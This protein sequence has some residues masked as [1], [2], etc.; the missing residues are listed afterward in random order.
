MPRGH[1]GSSES[2][3]PEWRQKRGWEPPARCKEEKD[4]GDE[5]SLPWYFKRGTD[6]AKEA[7]VRV[8]AA[9]E[10]VPE[11]AV[12]WYFKRGTREGDERG[13]K[14]SRS[15]DTFRRSPPPEPQVPWFFKRGT[16][17]QEEED[18]RLA[19]QTEAFLQNWRAAPPPDVKEEKE[20]HLSGE[21]TPPLGVA[22][23]P[24]CEGSD[25]EVTPPLP[26][27]ESVTPPLEEVQPIRPPEP[28]LPPKRRRSHLPPPPKPPPHVEVEGMVM[29]ALREKDPTIP[30]GWPAIV[31][32]AYTNEPDSV[33][34]LI[35]AKVDVNAVSSS[36]AS[37][38]WHAVSNHNLRM[39]YSLLEARADPNH[40]KKSAKGARR[41]LLDV[42][43]NDGAP[44]P[45]VNMLQAAGGLHREQLEGRR[46]P[47]FNPDQLALAAAEADVHRP[48]RLKIEKVVQEDTSF[49]SML[50]K[51]GDHPGTDAKS[52]A[53]SPSTPPLDDRRPGS[54]YAER[55]AFK[56]AYARKMLPL[57]GEKPV[58]DFSAYKS[59]PNS[60][61]YNTSVRP[62]DLMSSLMSEAPKRTYAGLVLP[63]IRGLRHHEADRWRAGL[64]AAQAP[65]GGSEAPEVL[66]DPW[67][68]ALAGKEKAKE[69]P[70][71]PRAKEMPRPPKAR[72]PPHLLAKARPKRA[73]PDGPKEGD[74][75]EPVPVK[76]KA[77]PRKSR[78]EDADEGVLVKAELPGVKGSETEVAEA[79][80]SEGTPSA[81]SAASAPAAESRDAE[82]LDDLPRLLEEGEEKKEE[83]AAAAAPLEPLPPM[84]LTGWEEAR[85]S[86]V[87]MDLVKEL[88]GGSKFHDP[89]RDPSAYRKQARNMC[90]IEVSKLKFCH[91]DIGP[92]F[93]HGKHRGQSVLNLLKDLHTGKSDPKELPPLVVMRN[94][95][96]LQVVCGNR[97]LYCLK[98]YALE[99]SCT[100]DVWC[101]VYDL[102][103][104]DTPRP[105]VFKYILA[106]TT[107][108]SSSVSA[109]KF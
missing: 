98:R 103:A 34:W 29:Q 50:M 6:K 20:E 25:G 93:T 78:T 42:A 63:G 49:Q 62:G 9:Q 60:A 7:S 55:S 30:Q 89:A 45:I 44:P 10:R 56:R 102:K 83:D 67:G 53:S 77:M 54:A 26:D 104:K 107:E 100:V 28:E 88:A 18:T 80:P 59:L 11:P 47:H 37:A 8:A 87:Q 86:E 17:A 61:A 97:R 71:A 2:P 14:R 65:A 99:K 58:L 5:A 33:Q 41:T 19:Q 57:C 76:A 92:R 84:R 13:R 27:D 69:P 105:L 66:R 52:E 96:D 64:G 21:D 3:T 32:A 15:Q 4:S 31:A 39:V 91:K 48:K 90:L 22:S 40:T 94:R 12:P 36:K 108:D 109:R 38:L 79:K 16:R 51:I 75:P 68:C 72:P 85:L 101:V 46:R 82:S 1:G 74:A 81:A 24:A 23:L 106:T 95:G 70:E 35:N 73:A 43:T